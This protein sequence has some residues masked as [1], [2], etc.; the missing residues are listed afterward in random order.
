MAPVG[1]IKFP[2]IVSRDYKKWFEQEHWKKLDKH[3]DELRKIL[4]N[5]NNKDDIQ[6][7][8]DQGN[9]PYGDILE[10]PNILIGEM[11][12]TGI[13]WAEG[14][15]KW[16][17]PKGFDLDPVQEYLNYLKYKIKE[18]DLHGVFSNME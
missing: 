1:L 15:G 13:R 12:G 14:I 9:F 3:G 7:C 18:E 8:K 16:Y 6:T 2:V 4:E 5:K 17:L 11:K 10:I